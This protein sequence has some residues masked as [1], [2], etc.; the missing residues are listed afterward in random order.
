METNLAGAA[1]KI[2]TRKIDLDKNLDRFEYEN[3][4]VEAPIKVFLNGKHLATV[5]ASPQNLAEMAFGLLIDEGVVPQPG[6]VVNVSIDKNEVWVESRRINLDRFK[7]ISAGVIVTSCSSRTDF[8]RVIEELK[9]SPLPLEQRVEASDIL[10]M[11][12]ELVKRSVTFRS[13]GGVHSA[14]LFIDGAMEGFAEDVGRHNAVDKAIG[15]CLMKDVPLQ[16]AV[17]VTSGRQPADIVLKAARCRIP[18]SV[19]LRAPL[20]SGVYAADLTGVTLICFARGR[21]MN[22]YSHPER[23]NPLRTI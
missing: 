1:M 15:S 23:I 18:I 2:K 9:M 3:V 21:R 8:H 16:R 10:D 22:V 14:A 6:D 7:S 4:A 20:S 12:A 19:S 5:M 13:T 11:A 17:L